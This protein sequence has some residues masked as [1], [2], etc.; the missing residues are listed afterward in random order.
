MIKLLIVDDEPLVQA[1]IRSMVNWEDLNISIVGIAANGA[2]AYEMIK[3]YEVE[4]VI[5]DIKMPVMSGLALARKCVDSGMDV[6]VFIFLTGYED[7]HYAK[8]ALTVQAIDYLIKL[9]LTP[10]ALIQS[11]D[12]AIARLS[13]LR[14]SSRTPDLAINT[15]F[16]E[17]FFT[18]LIF[19][20]FEDEHQFLS[21]S[22]NLKIDFDYE[23]YATGY[24]EIDSG[25]LTDM[26]A[27]KPISSL[28][29]CR[30]LL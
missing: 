30:L 27:E 8:E 21:Q 3:K 15:I 4:I 2:A 7:F 18:R 24:I 13:E 1:G 25:R 20:L 29:S 12:R 19:N 16:R 9:E 5:T 17:Q 22:K 23:L 10:E 14:Y 26:A 11:L 6:P 28:T